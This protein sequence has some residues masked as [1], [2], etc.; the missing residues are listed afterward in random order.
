MCVV[1]RLGSSVLLGHPLALLAP[2][3]DAGPGYP[4][5]PELLPPALQGPTS[6]RAEPGILLGSHLPWALLACLLDTAPTWQFLITSLQSL[7]RWFIPSK[8]I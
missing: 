7:F 4:G 6:P 5:E 8:S 1:I 2:A 3:G